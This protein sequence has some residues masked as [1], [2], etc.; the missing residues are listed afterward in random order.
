MRGRERTEREENKERERV[1]LCLAAAQT[2]LEHINP[3]H[4]L[5][6]LLTHRV[7]ERREG[8]R[9]RWSVAGLRGRRGE[10]VSMTE[11]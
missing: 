3:F 5:L 10:G 2:T 7:G 8:W 4:W 6:W 11:P 1:T 9:A